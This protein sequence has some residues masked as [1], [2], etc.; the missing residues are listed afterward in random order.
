MLWQKDFNPH[1]LLTDYEPTA[2]GLSSVLPVS[3]HHETGGTR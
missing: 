3:S 2:Y 1:D